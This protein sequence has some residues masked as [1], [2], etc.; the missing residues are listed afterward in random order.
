[1][2]RVRIEASGSYDVLI[3]PGLIHRAGELT[4]QVMP[5][6]KA[7]II[8]DDTVQALYGD[9]VKKSL[10]GAGFS[11]DMWAFP[12]GEQHKTLDTLAQALAWLYA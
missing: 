7:A 6:C 12:H 5:P 9:I 2:K 1:M 8:T 11:V 10:E 4:R 3:G